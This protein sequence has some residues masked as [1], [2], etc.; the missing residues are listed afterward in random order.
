MNIE[1]EAK[2]K[3]KKFKKHLR[4]AI[5]QLS[6]AG[7]YASPEQAKELF[8]YTEQLLDIEIDINQEISTGL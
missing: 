7:L 8:K 4:K 5:R 6:V 3:D 1:K 2:K